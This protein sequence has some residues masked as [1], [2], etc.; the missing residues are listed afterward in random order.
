MTRD[1][2]GDYR[3]R[4]FRFCCWLERWRLAC[5]VLHIPHDVSYERVGRATEEQ[6]YPFGETTVTTPTLQTVADKKEIYL[7]LSSAAQACEGALFSCLSFSLLSLF[8]LLCLCSR[9]AG[10][11]TRLSEEDISVH[12]G[13]A[14][15]LERCVEGMLSSNVKKEFVKAREALGPLLRELDSN[16]DLVRFVKKYRSNADGT[17][18]LDAFYAPILLRIHCINQY[19]K[20]K[21]VSGTLLWLLVF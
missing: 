1:V 20:E 18:F 8:S 9:R 5:I 2:N 14:E 12:I 19:T 17:H 10:W 13:R 4:G 7:L 6:K 15:R 3:L 11:M 16:G 21:M